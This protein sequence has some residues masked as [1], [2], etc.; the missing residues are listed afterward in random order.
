MSN[1]EYRESGSGFCAICD[2]MPGEGAH[3]PQPNTEIP[4]TVTDVDTASGT[5][6]F[7]LPEE[8]GAASAQHNVPGMTT[9]EEPSYM[10]FAR[11]NVKDGLLTTSSVVRE[12]L[13]RID[14]LEKAQQAVKGVADDLQTRGDF[15]EEKGNNGSNYS[16]RMEGRGIGYREAARSIYKALEGEK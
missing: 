6:T 15:I 7:E 14:R 3:A 8:Y 13:V 1:H 9:K 10:M 12:L 16:H 4:V 2:A 11:A 5:I